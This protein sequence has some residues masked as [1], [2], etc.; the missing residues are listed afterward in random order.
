M[1][2]QEF[3]SRVKMAVSSKEYSSIEEVYMNSDL[4]KDEFCKMWAKM[5]KSRIAKAKAEQDYR[6]RISKVQDIILFRGE[7]NDYS[8]TITA[9]L[10]SWE[11]IDLFESVGLKMEYS[12]EE[13]GVPRFKRVCETMGDYHNLIQSILRA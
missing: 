8:T 6:N 5:N 9:S 13:M 11:E 2:Q 1:T 7:F 4:D 10:L 3:E 12:A